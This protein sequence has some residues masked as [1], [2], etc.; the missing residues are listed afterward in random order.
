MP[1]ENVLQLCGM[2]LPEGRAAIILFERFPMLVCPSGI[3]IDLD[4]LDFLRKF[5]HNGQGKPV[6]ALRGLDPI[7]ISPISPRVLH[8][9]QQDEMVG[10]ANQVEITLPGNVVRLGYGYG[11]AHR[12]F[13]ARLC[14]LKNR[15]RRLGHVPR[16]VIA[17]RE[18]LLNRHRM[19]RQKRSQL[20]HH[21]VL[22]LGRDLKI[23]R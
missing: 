4:L 11:L 8:V 2:D 23:K 3:V 16:T 9:V 13:P 17:P 18:G 14:S 15:F 5:P 7:A 10:P 21:S 12:I 19:R 20:L 22:L 1:F 6:R